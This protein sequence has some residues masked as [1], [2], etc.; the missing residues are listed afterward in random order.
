MAGIRSYYCS[1]Q[2]LNKMNQV[3]EHAG[4]HISEASKIDGEFFEVMENSA[5]I[6]FIICRPKDI[7][8]TP[9]PILLLPNCKQCPFINKHIKLLEKI[10]R[11]LLASGVKLKQSPE[12]A[13]YIYRTSSDQ[14][15]PFI[16]LVHLL[17]DISLSDEDLYKSRY[18][19]ENGIHYIS[20]IISSQHKFYTGPAYNDSSGEYCHFFALECKNNIA[21]D[22]LI[23]LE[24]T[25]SSN[26][27][28]H[29]P[30]LL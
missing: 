29:V 2:L 19:H 14:M 28:E 22:K 25:L 30:L 23:S 3:L 7:R 6:G 8:N 21:E 16:S 10:E 24:K 5:R 15:N 4:I 17:S 11:V 12:Q 26:G 18:I 1:Q 20:G 9:Y 13:K 27:L